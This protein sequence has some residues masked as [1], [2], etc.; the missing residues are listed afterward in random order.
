MQHISTL[1]LGP[2]R[3]GARQYLGITIDGRR[4]AEL[5]VPPGQPPGHMDYIAPFGWAGE[6]WAW[7]AAEAAAHLL[8]LRPPELESGRRALL[9]CPECAHLS[10]GAITAAVER[11]GDRY[12]WR[13]FDIESSYQPYEGGPVAFA[14]MPELVFDARPYERLLRGMLG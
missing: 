2:Q 9:V 12:I 7:L 4:L 6:T 5:L 11:Q 14:H 1:G 3:R 10:C 13:G 8:L